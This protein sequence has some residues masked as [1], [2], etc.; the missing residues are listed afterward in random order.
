[1]TLNHLLLSNHSKATTNGVIHWI[2][3]DAERFKLLIELVVGNNIILAQRAAWPMSYIVIEQPNLVY[4]HLNKLLD[5]V[6]KN[7]HPA[8]KRNTFRFLKEI[9]IPENS[10]T[11]AIEACFVVVNNPKEPI[12]VICFAFYSLLKFARRFPELKNEI[13]FA[14]EL[15][16]ENK[17]SGLQNTL[18]KVR[19]E[20]YKQSL[21]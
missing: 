17:A 10:I 21:G 9:E 8:I 11:K 13:L 4:P 19:K 3:N 6:V 16:Q 20:L 18:K 15:H 2:G 14:A 12:A 5:E 1:M 7:V